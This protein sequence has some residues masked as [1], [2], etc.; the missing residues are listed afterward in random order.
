MTSKMK[1]FVHPTTKRYYDYGSLLETT[2][3]IM[4]S[5]DGENIHSFEEGKTIADIRARI[6]ALGP[7]TAAAVELVE[8][9]PISRS[10][11]MN[12]HGLI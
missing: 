1:L 7:E 10:H 4:W 5:A 9:R 2:T 3:G 8:G 6:E 12:P 11:D